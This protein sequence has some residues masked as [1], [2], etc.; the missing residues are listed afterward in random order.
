VP[1]SGGLAVI[2]VF[3]A[4]VVTDSADTYVWVYR[5][6]PTRKEVIKRLWH[7]ERAEELDWYMDTTSVYIDETDL[8][9]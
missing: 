3:T 1:L 9:D 5:N 8:I 2:K 7:F 4:R 6:K